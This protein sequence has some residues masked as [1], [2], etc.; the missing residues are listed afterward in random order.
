METNNHNIHIPLQAR[1]NVD[2]PLHY[3]SCTEDGVDCITAMQSA[4]GKE[5]TS[6][7]CRLNA[8]KYLWRSTRKNGREDIKK[9]LWYLNKYITLTEPQNQNTDGNDSSQGSPLE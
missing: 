4:F 6:A 7:F 8:F 2:N 1:N 9:A 5:T 3:Q